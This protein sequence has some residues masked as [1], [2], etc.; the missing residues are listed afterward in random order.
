MTLMILSITWAPKETK[1]RASF[2]Q[3]PQQINR[4]AR[5]RERRRML[6]TGHFTKVSGKLTIMPN[7]RMKLM[8]FLTSQR[9]QPSN[10][11]RRFKN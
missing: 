9:E 11:W 3:E 7:T 8:H 1:S 5:K 2:Q 4:R 6:T 10:L